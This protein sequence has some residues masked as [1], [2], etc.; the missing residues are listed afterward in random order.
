[1]ASAFHLRRLGVRCVVLD[2][3]ERPGGAWQHYWDSLRLFSPAEHSPLPGWP[4]PPEDGAAFC[5][6]QHVVDYF[7][8]YEQRYHLP[9]ERPVRVRRVR[10][11]D[12]GF[13][14]VADAGE[15]RARAV[16]N[17]TG[18]WENP[19]LPSLPGTFGG[20][21]LHT[22]DYRT[23]EPFR[24][25]RVV[26]VGGGNSGAQILA[27]VSTVASTLWATRRPPR[28]MPDDVDG[29]VLFDVATARE[30]ARRA[31]RAHA[32]VQGIGDIVMV[33]PVK[34]A[35]DRG[36]LE[37]H[38][39]FDRLTPT[40]VAWDTGSAWDCDAII[41]CT[42]FAPNLAH[43]HGLD[44]TWEG[45]HPRVAEYASVDHPGLFFI[46]YGDWTGFASATIIG[47][48]RTTKPAMARVAAFV[49]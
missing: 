18:R 23:A 15:L 11:V 16:V 14:V 10:V 19:V 13:V 32:G 37:A 3:A 20:R 47:A 2:A 42:G 39:M 17:A 41:W 26:V 30:A 22:V 43:L 40:G 28:L 5:S 36:A 24:G 7:T 33:P 8:A 49:A 44:L 46:G 31:G 1:M 25:Q 34:D 12:D 38:P 9:V 48:T 27:E 6:R 21:Q 4:M 35:R 29:R 45:G